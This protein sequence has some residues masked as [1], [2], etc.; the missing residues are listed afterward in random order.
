MLD[1]ALLDPPNVHVQRHSDPLLPHP[2]HW[3]IETRRSPRPQECSVVPS[4]SALQL[5]RNWSRQEGG[6]RGGSATED[7]QSINSSE[8]DDG[9]MF[10]FVRMPPETPLPHWFPTLNVPALA[11]A[12]GDHW[13]LGRDTKSH[14]GPEAHNP[15][16][17]VFSA[18]EN[19]A[20]SLA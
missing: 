16:T 10:C 19:P 6:G 20:T 7:V 2:Q 17:C 3:D 11:G 1:D 18:A 12:R 4:P 9:N 13:T 15:C 8:D 14:R 5:L